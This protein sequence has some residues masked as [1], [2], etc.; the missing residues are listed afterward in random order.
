MM[1]EAK[2]LQFR[3]SIHPYRTHNG[4]RDLRKRHTFH[5]SVPAFGI[6]VSDDRKDRFPVAN[7]LSVACYTYQGRI[8]AHRYLILRLQWANHS[9]M[10]LRLEKQL[11]DHG[12]LGIAKFIGAAGITHHEDEVQL[13]SS[14]KE[15][16]QEGSKLESSLKLD[17]SSRKTVA[18]LMVFLHVI[19][20]EVA[21]YNL[22]PVGRLLYVYTWLELPF[23]TIW[24]RKIAGYGA[25]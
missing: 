9:D 16:I 2:E 20:E 7:I 12:A 22:W 13:S 23:D 3:E 15:L 11:D 21:I 10:Y 6:F 14:K 18:E 24:D 25:P 19:T 5:N 1:Q 8:V 17:S 4:D